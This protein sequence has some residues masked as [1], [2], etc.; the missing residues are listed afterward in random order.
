MA[1]VLGGGNGEAF[2]FTTAIA[3]FALE[4]MHESQGLVD[5]TRVVT[6]NQGDTYLVPNFA[7][8]TYQDYN[9]AT[10]P[11][12]GA[13]GFGFGVAPAAVEQNPALTQGSIQATPAV[14][15]TAF[16]VF[17]SWTTSFEL[18]ATIGEELGGS[19]GEKVDQRVAAAFLAFGDTA[20][21]ALANSGNVTTVGADGF[22]VIVSLGS[23]ELGAQGVA[24]ALPSAFAD[25]TVLGIVQKIKQNYVVAKLPGT[26]IVVLDSDGDDG[27]VGSSMIRALSELSGGAVTTA[28]NQGGS[29]ITSLGEELLATGTLTNLYG[30]RIIF[31]NFLLTQTGG[32]QRDVNNILS[33][34]KVGAYFHET[35]IFTV[36]KEG[37]QVKI[38]EKPGGLQMW[39]TG[40]AYMGSGIADV[41]RGGAISIQQA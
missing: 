31:S 26:P 10:S 2:G 27:V 38:G 28:V 41:R 32:A 4:A 29:A 12:T 25:N 20:R 21:G 33:D 24:I 17:Y 39:L 6:P 1:Y 18:A 35:C 30:C 34:V 37:L 40:L 23:M 13:S 3:N 22:P 16:D 36:I 9:P 14:A 5:Y 8:I 15:A 7:A 11:G 19:Y